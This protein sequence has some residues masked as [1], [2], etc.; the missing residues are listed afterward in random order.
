MSLEEAWEKVLKEV[1]EAASGARHPFRYVMLATVDKTNSP[2]Q[3]TVVLRDFADDSEFTVFTDCRSEKVDQI[4]Q[5]GA[6][7]LLF[8]HDEKKLQLRV[9]G[10]ARILKIGEEVDRRWQDGASENPEPY[11]SVIPP[12]ATIENP[13]K[14]YRWDLE[15]TPNF[16][17]LKIRAASMEFLQLDGVKHIRGEKK[18]NPGGEDRVKWIAP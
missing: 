14:A 18:M 7:S 9:A 1:S 5:N 6:V 17:I 2:R 11:T 10:T 4:A 15:G 8:Y 16:C 3:R 13:E 12:G